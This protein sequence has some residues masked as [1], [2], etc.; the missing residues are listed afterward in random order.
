MPS[1]LTRLAASL[2]SFVGAY[3]AALKRADDYQRAAFIGAWAEQSAWQGG[4]FIREESARRAMLNAWVYSAVGMIMR[5]VS[6]AKF[7]VKKFVD[8][9][10]DSVD[11]PNHPL[12]RLLRRPNPWMGR[13]FLWQYTTAW[14]MLDGNAYWFVGA[15]QEDRTQVHE[16]WPLPAQHVL[17]MAGDAQKFVDHYEFYTRG[18]I[19]KIPAEYIVHMMLPNPFD[20]F[21]GLSPLSAAMLAVD[22]DIAMARW[23]GAFFGQ[24]STMP[25][26]II[27]LSSGDPNR[28]INEA[29]A[30]ALKTD[31]REEYGAT[32][33]KTAITTAYKL[34]VQLLGWNP[35]DMDFI[36]GRDFTRKEIFNIY[37]VPEGLMS[38][39]ATEANA[40]TGDRVFKEK[41]I[42]P[43]LG[44]MAEQLTA[45]LVAPF[46][47]KDY[48][49]G[50]EDIRPTD[51]ALQ[52]QEYEAAKDVLEIDELR[53]DYFKKP[54]REGDKGKKL[55]NEIETT[56]PELGAG[57]DDLEQ[58]LLGLPAPTQPSTPTHDRLLPAP[59]AEPTEPE[60]TVK[61]VRPYAR[62][63]RQ[64]RAAAIRRFKSHAGNGRIEAMRRWHS[65]WIPGE[66]QDDIRIGLELATSVDDVY[67]A[68]EVEPW[69]AS[70]RPWSLFESKLFQ[71]VRAVLSNEAQRISAEMVGR[72]QD[73]VTDPATWTAHEARLK[74]EIG[75]VVER[76]AQYGVEQ[77]RRR[78]LNVA[79]PD[80]NW[81]LVNER[82]IDWARQYTFELVKGIADTT[83]DELQR[84]TSEWIESGKPLS[85][86]VEAIARIRLP[87][88]G[89]KPIEPFSPSRARSIAVTEATRVYAHGNA[90]GFEN[91]G[92]AAASYL[93]PAHVGDRCYIQ[94]YKLP[95][96]TWVMV[97]YTVNDRRVCTQPL[98]TPWGEMLG[99]KDLHKRVISDGPYGGLK[100]EDAI[101]KAR[102]QKKAFVSNKTDVE[103]VPV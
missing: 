2:G 14:L 95:D 18:T 94:P 80:V 79:P 17:P 27:N 57:L 70:P 62:D 23:N 87:G 85:E 19:Y 8:V 58:Q 99:C 25:S 59:P 24:D 67:H 6:A 36:Q 64:W 88:E 60:E 61:D 30:K 51:R 69:K 71:V 66:L 65:D 39:N 55:L 31:L 91:S 12:E 4:D 15:G 5:E 22:S 63:L 97:W 103:F 7:E 45:E 101:A 28:P 44:L 100:L 74:N 72:G 46:Y 10:E 3:R 73:A 53:R 89:G 50:F 13:A 21:R 92:V 84:A 16:I 86:L 56:P 93:P 81:N 68:F 76:L 102:Q 32:K 49:A 75:P 35:K 54:P 34:E 82:A 52:L 43:L 33:R 9:D 78:L 47:G 48:E 29:D 98:S 11:V 83:R 40:Q 96:N 77:A 26:A 38:E 1:P 37:G 20:P 42:W 41:T 90:Q